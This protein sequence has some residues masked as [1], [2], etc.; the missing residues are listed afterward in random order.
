[1]NSF[2]LML[3]K[4]YSFKFFD[5]FILIYPLY[6]VM[7]SDNGFLFYCSFGRLRLSFWRYQAG[8]GL[9]DILVRIFL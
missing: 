4:I 1:M 3:V 6:A 8:C 2:K 5:D 7:F 9:I